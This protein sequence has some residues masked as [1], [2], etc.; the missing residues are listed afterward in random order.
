MKTRQR[1]NFVSLECSRLLTK[2]GQLIL[3]LLFG[4]S[5]FLAWLPSQINWFPVAN[6]E[7]SLCAMFFPPFQTHKYS[8]YSPRGINQRQPCQVLCSCM[9]I[10]FFFFTY[11]KMVYF[12]FSSSNALARLLL[13]QAPADGWKATWFTDKSLTQN[14][15][16]CLSPTLSLILVLIWCPLRQRGMFFCGPQHRNNC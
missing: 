4:A 8:P 14:T 11:L 1:T 15:K 13:H 5:L 10:S 16:K 9:C 6:S 12:C 2:S 7:Y 3:T